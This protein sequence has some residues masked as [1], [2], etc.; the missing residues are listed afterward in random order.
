MAACSNVSGGF[1]SIF[2]C[3]ED[4]HSANDDVEMGL[5]MQKLFVRPGDSRDSR[6]LI[7]FYTDPPE[8]FLLGPVPSWLSTYDKYPPLPVYGFWIGSAVRVDTI[9]YVLHA[10]RVVPRG[11]HKSLMGEKN[12]N[13]NNSVNTK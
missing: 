4:E 2:F 5:S 3:R 6:G 8:Q 1:L 10:R 7:T 12:I 9:S 13:I 11:C